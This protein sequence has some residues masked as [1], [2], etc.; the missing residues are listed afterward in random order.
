VTLIDIVACTVCMGAPGDPLV[1]GANAGIWVLLAII[2]AV[3]IGFVALFVAFWRRG[4]ELKKFREQFR[5]ITGGR[6]VYSERSEES[7]VQPA[8][9]NGATPIAHRR[10][11]TVS[12]LFQRSLAS[13]GINF[14]GGSR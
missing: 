5:V 3:Q 9:Q 14:S 13:L 8:A 6:E 11:A 2:F 12:R 10:R 7:P 1:K 4:R